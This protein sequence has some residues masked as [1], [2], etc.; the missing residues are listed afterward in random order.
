MKKVIALLADGFE[1]IECIATVDLL[2]RAGIRVDL[3]SIKDDVVQG[4]L[5]TKVVT[6][7]LLSDIQ[8]EYD[9]LFLPGGKGVGKLDE[10][11]LVKSLIKE[12]NQKG[13]LVTAICAAPLI[14][15]KMGLLDN[16]KFTCYPEFEEFMPKGI[17]TPVGAVKD[18]NIITGK[19]VGFVYDFALMLIEELV[20]LDIKNKVYES[21]L[22]KEKSV[23]K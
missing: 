19:G 12:Y 2:R 21:T 16:K 14:L 20:G 3:A 11:D 10:S 5:G 23:S 7:L 22:I 6:D 17:H 9:A 18:G 4:G 1:D 13:K 15:G 8:E